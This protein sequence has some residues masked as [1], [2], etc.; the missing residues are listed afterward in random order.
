MKFLNILF[1]KTE[2]SDCL[3]SFCWTA[4]PT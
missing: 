1:E 4:C 2:N 3:P